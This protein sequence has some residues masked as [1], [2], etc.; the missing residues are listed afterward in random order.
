MPVGKAFS[1]FGEQYGILF[2]DPPYDDETIG[3]VAE[4][5]V[6]SPM[7]GMSSTMVIEHSR[8]M[9]LQSRYGAFDEIRSIRHGD[10]CVSFYQHVEV[11]S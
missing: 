8:R 10:S 5:L 4:K 7:V 11:A 2:L 6:A 9:P 3:Q 1:T